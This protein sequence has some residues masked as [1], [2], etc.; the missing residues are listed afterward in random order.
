MAALD[1]MVLEHLADRLFTPERLTGLLE[2]YIARSAEADA[3]RRQRLGQARLRAT[4]IEGKLTRLVQ[5][6][7]QGLLEPDDPA[8][9]DELTRLKAQRGLAQEEV[10]RLEV[11]KAGNQTITPEKIARFSETLRKALHADDTVFRK[12]YLRLFVDE[13]VVGERELQMRGPTG[14]LASAVGAA[15]IPPPAEMVPS[16]ILDWRPVRDS[17]PCCQR[18]RLESWASRRTGP[19]AGA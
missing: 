12:A 18:E 13:V 8:L 16:F 2:A 6:V 3:T 10:R 1:G 5:L 4:E 15:G 19:R 9:G 14:A 17:N 11:S 7:A